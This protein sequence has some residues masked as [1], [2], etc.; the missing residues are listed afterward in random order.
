M[1]THIAFMP[2]ARFLS[3]APDPLVVVVSITDS[4]PR[5]VRPNLEGYHDA[6]RL[7]FVDVAEEHVG[8]AVGSWPVEPTPEEHE[9]L[10]EL[11]GERLPA[12][13]DA[14]AVRR[15]LDKHHAAANRL[16]VLVHCFAGA[17]RSAAVAQWAAT[18]YGIPLEDVAGRGTSASNERVLRLLDLSTRDD[19]ADGVER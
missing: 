10:G 12:L 6:L 15:F 13:S 5:A 17:S 1:L 16:A 9:K 3:L 19:E 8:D 18:N 14:L 11:R 2:L 4:S 7:E